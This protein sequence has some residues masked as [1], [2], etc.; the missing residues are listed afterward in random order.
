M[1]FVLRS[2]KN[3]YRLN[4]SWLSNNS[5][6][7]PKNLTALMKSLD[8]ITPIKGQQRPTQQLARGNFVSLV[9]VRTIELAVSIISIS[10]YQFVKIGQ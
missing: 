2:L 10:A 7:V 8:I 3:A 5:V 4:T 6:F 1:D 9:F